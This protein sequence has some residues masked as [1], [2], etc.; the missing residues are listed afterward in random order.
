MQKKKEYGYDTNNNRILELNFYGNNNDWDSTYKRVMSY[1]INN[2]EIELVMSGFTNSAWENMNKQEHDYN[3]ANNVIEYRAFNWNDDDSSWNINHEKIIYNYDQNNNLIEQ[4][5][6]HFNSESTL[7]ND[8]KIEYVFDTNNNLSE[9]IYFSWEEV[10]SVWRIS[11]KTAL[12]FDTNYSFEHLIL[13]VDLSAQSFYFRNMLTSFEGYEFD[14]DSNSW[15]LS[16]QLSLYYSEISN[17]IDTTFITSCEPFSW[18]GNILD[19]TGI[20]LDTLQN[21][22]GEDSLV[23]L[24][25][26]IYAPVNAEAGSDVA[27]CANDSVILNG[28]GGVQYNWEPSE[29]V[30][31]SDSGIVIAFPNQSMDFT[32]EVT[33]TNGCIGYDTLNINILEISVSISSFGDSLG[34]SI[35]QEAESI[36]WNTG[37]TTSTITPNSNGIYTITVTNQIGCIASDSIVFENVSTNITAN[38]SNLIKLF[39]NPTSNYINV[40]ANKLIN[41]T[42]IDSEKFLFE[43]FDENGRKVLS[44]SININGSLD[45]S[46]LNEG[47]YFYNL[48][49]NGDV[50]SG[51]I[52]KK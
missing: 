18:G 44:K 8:L 2:N 48:H 43:L 41:V 40:S 16:E 38:N 3:S 46:K 34:A 49:L 33:D 13:P 52:I 28:S 30:E 24:D 51:R 10:D 4:I 11:S 21:I 37:D 15:Y 35:S 17:P 20:Y 23:G 9:E 29:F 25:L 1:D 14:D 36:Y 22:F 39:P 6:Y 7:E 5:E 12:T 50:K 31:Y 47:I 32:L 27:I 26:T 42:G 19:T 45:L